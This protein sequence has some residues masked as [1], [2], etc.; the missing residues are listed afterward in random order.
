MSQQRWGEEGAGPQLSTSVL[1]VLW[2]VLLHAMCCI[3]NLQHSS[4][5]GLGQRIKVGLKP[6]PRL[7]ARAATGATILD[8]GPT[9]L[10]PPQQQCLSERHGASCLCRPV[11]VT[12]ISVSDL[13]CSCRCNSLKEGRFQ[14]P[15][16]CCWSG[17]IRGILNLLTLPRCLS[18]YFR[19]LSFC[20]ALER[21]PFPTPL[22]HNTNL[23]AY[24][25]VPGHRISNAKDL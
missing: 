1:F 9:F 10:V 21:V 17:Q 6:Q 20:I 12:G 11:S 22:V 13:G 7:T 15:L 14:K 23:C 25:W 5:N 18:G 2:E 16:S 3:F 19:S 8:A 24:I 4:S